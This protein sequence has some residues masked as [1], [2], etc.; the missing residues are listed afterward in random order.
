MEYEE[1]LD[2]AVAN[3]PEVKS[4]VE[5]LEQQMDENEVSFG[6]LPSGDSIARDFQRFLREQGPR[7]KLART[8][9]APVIRLSKGRH[10]LSE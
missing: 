7:A 10:S 4:L 9:G 6:D 8:L 1:R 3:E 5:R 2:E